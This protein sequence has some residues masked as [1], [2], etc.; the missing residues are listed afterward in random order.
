MIQKETVKN[1][2][3]RSP[4]L[5]SVCGGETVEETSLLG[6]VKEDESN[7]EASHSQEEPTRIDA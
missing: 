4:G 1:V 6:E 5:G 2:D 7:R 3:G